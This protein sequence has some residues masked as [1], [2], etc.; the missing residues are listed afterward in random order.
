MRVFV[1][2][3]GRFFFSFDFFEEEEDGIVVLWFFLE[4]FIGMEVSG[5]GVGFLLRLEG[6]W[7]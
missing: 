1:E 4:V 3:K 7:G 5:F 2:V 6:C